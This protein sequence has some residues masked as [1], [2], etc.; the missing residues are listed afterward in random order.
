MV[1]PATCSSVGFHLQAP[2]EMDRL[3]D[4]CIGHCER[5]KTDFQN[6]LRFWQIPPNRRLERIYSHNHF[7]ELCQIK[8]Q[9]HPGGGRGE[10]KGVRKKELST[11]CPLFPSNLL[12]PQKTKPSKGILANKALSRLSSPK[13][14]CFL[15]HFKSMQILGQAAFSNNNQC[16]LGKIVSCSRMSNDN[17]AQKSA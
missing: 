17:D 5:K 12:S 8:E 13:L 6:F 14:K 2:A 9:H 11:S 4:F 1:R 10:A 3:A 16:R 7:L 15:E